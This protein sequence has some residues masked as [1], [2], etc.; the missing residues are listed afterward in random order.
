MSSE[1]EYDVC[2]EKKKKLEDSIYWIGLIDE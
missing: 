2:L 1:T